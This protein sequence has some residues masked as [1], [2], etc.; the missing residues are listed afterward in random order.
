MPT[1]DDYKQAKS[2]P[3]RPAGPGR[4]TDG[5]IR[6]DCAHE[7][8]PDEAAHPGDNGWAEPAVRPKREPLLVVDL[9]LPDPRLQ[10]LTGDKPT[11]PHRRYDHRNCLCGAIRYVAEPSGRIRWKHQH[12]GCP[13]IAALKLRRY[14]KDRSAYDPKPRPRRNRL[15]PK[16][17]KLHQFHKLLQAGAWLVLC[18]YD[19]ITGQKK[20]KYPNW[21]L[22]R[23]DFAEVMRHLEADDKNLIGIIP[24][25]VG[26][27]VIDVDHDDWQATAVK[28]G[29]TIT[30]ATCRRHCRHLWAPIDRRSGR[31]STH[32]FVMRDDAGAFISSGDLRCRNGYVIIW[33]KRAVDNALRMARIRDGEP[34]DQTPFRAAAMRL[35][36]APSTSSGGQMPASL[37]CAALYDAQMSAVVRHDR[38]VANALEARRL[39]DAGRT[40]PEL[41][42]R[43]E[44]SRST[45]YRWLSPSL[46]TSRFLTPRELERNAAEAAATKHRKTAGKYLPSWLNQN[47]V[48]PNR[49]RYTASRNSTPTSTTMMPMPTRNTISRAR[50]TPSPDAVS[51]IITIPAQPKLMVPST[52]AS[53]A[54]N[55]H[56]LFR[57]SCR[58]FNAQLPSSQVRMSPPSSS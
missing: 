13:F 42:T 6:H 10:P 45:I 17:L 40:I 3:A 18:Y 23:P 39:H 31:I 30:N 26:A 1:F 16:M 27:I 14:A 25:S 38:M 53:S 47:S 48:T 54:R 28:L 9:P 7:Y 21:V 12:E 35:Y 57:F 51:C 19:E 11:P 49:C 32:G 41:M 5:A 24:E 8:E 44:R 46:D 15:L 50:L 43:Y 2:Q 20:P 34:T 56:V 29:T 55:C 37:H 36:R 52:P 58:Y 33:N 22:M 4:P